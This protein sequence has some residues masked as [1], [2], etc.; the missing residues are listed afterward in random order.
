[1]NRRLDIEENQISE[2]EAIK[3]DTIWKNN[4]NK[5]KSPSVS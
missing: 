3:V 5:K 1:M 4:N 2:L